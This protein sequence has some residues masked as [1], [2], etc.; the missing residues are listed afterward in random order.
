V[1]R[2]CC[3]AG[4]PFAGGDQLFQGYTL[5]R[6]PFLCKKK[7]KRNSPAPCHRCTRGRPSVGCY[8]ILPALIL[9]LSPFLLLL[10]A[11]RGQIS[12]PMPFLRFS[13]RHRCGIFP[14]DFL[15]CHLRFHVH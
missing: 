15:M 9:A 12:V 1:P 5:Y 10:A 7:K 11:L 13:D 4:C 2:R 3:T 14:R 6:V 8:Q